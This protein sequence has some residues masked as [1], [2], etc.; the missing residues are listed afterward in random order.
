MNI[1]H[2]K[3][4]TVQSVDDFLSLS[5]LVGD[6]LFFVVALQSPALSYIKTG[7]KINLLFKETEVMLATTTSKVSTQ[8][9]FVSKIKEVEVGE[10]FANVVFDFEGEEIS[11]FITKTSFEELSCSVSETFLWFIKANEITIQNGN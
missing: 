9:A 11:A 5:V 2:G 10:L 3:V 4:A 8:N 6:K 7:C 1:L